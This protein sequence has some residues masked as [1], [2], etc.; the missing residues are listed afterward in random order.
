MQDAR[1]DTRY[2]FYTCS[3]VP[4]ARIIFSGVIFGFV[5]ILMACA[6]F[7]AIKTRK[8]HIKELN[9]AKYITAIV[10]VT[11]LGS[12]IHIVCT[13]TLR[14]RVDTFPAALTGIFMLLITVV[15]G[16]VFVPKVTF[17]E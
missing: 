16:L 11:S 3:R 7:M 2:E 4:N 14:T 12:M 10:Y 5:C 13:F 15:L 9:D 8:V 1:I 17:M 6:L